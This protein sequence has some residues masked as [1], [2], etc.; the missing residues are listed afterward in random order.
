MRTSR[1]GGGAVQRGRRRLRI[2]FG[3]DVQVQ[4]ASSADDDTMRC[5]GPTAA[6]AE[7]CHLTP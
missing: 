4:R 1:S 6:E 5:D 3:D 7:K 2:R